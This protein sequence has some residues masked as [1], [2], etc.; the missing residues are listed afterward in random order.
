MIVA[1][2]RAQ[3]SSRFSELSSKVGAAVSLAGSVAILAYVVL[4]YVQRDVVRMRGVVL[5]LILFG[6][7][8]II[9]T[10]KPAYTPISKHHTH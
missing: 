8:A 1:A 2:M 4:S 10:E 6:V 7:A 5:S 3:A 9:W